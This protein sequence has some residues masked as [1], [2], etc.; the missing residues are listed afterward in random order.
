M[1]TQVSSMQGRRP[2]LLCYCSSFYS[3]PL[4][5]KPSWFSLSNPPKKLSTTSPHSST[6]L[7]PQEP[8]SQSLSPGLSQVGRQ[9][10]QLV[11]A[12]VHNPSPTGQTRPCMPSRSVPGCLGEVTHVRLLRPHC[13][14]V[15]ASQ[16]GPSRDTGAFL[17]R[18][19][20]LQRGGRC[21]P[22][23]LALSSSLQP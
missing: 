15:M 6:Q 1:L 4:E 23:A 18:A 21:D 7:S 5:G 16:S 17:L 22:Q 2:P 19:V 13:W 14:S 20:E 8:C 12:P 10:P 9:W 3:F 11:S